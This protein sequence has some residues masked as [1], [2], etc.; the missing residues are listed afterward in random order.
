MGMLARFGLIL[1]DA[2]RTNLQFLSDGFRDLPIERSL[3]AVELRELIGR[4][5]PILVHKRS[6][7]AGDAVDDGARSKW[8]NDLDGFVAVTLRPRLAGT[9]L[10]ALW[11]DGALSRMLD[12]VVAS[13]Q[14]LVAVRA[15]HDRT[16]PVT[17]RFDSHWAL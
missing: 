3:L 10:L 14:Q 8:A 7:L 13:E 6:K 5:L 1:A 17:S 9:S 2:F 16:L 12:A 4:D 15:R 11:N